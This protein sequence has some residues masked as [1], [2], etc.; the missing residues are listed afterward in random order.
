MSM[1]MMRAGPLRPRAVA[2][3]AGRFALPVL[4][5]GLLLGSGGPGPASGAGGESFEALKKA[6]ED[7]LAK[8]A[9][10]RIPAL[11]AIG[12]C[13]D[14]RAGKYIADLLAE[15]GKETGLLEVA[16]QCLGLRGDPAA[17][18]AA[19]T[20]G[21]KVL[22]ETRWRSVGE[23]FT[24]H[25]T[26][27]GQKWFLERGY[28]MIPTLPAAAQRIVV[29]LLL[30]ITDER[31]AEVA[32]KL[33]GNRKCPSA[34]QADFVDLLRIHRVAS[35]AKKI[36]GMHRFDDAKLQV[37]VLRALRD[38]E[39]AEHSK[40]FLDSIESKHWEVRSIAVDILGETHD[41]AMIPQITPL[42]SD[43][44][45]E[46]QVAAIQALRKIG[47]RDVVPPLIAALE[48]A[49]GR[50]RDDIADTLM[51]LLGADMGPDAIAWSTWWKLHGETAEVKGITR[52]EFDRL[53]E[54]AA[55]SQTGTYYGLRVIS[56]YVTF[57]I[58]VSGSM[59]EPYMVEER[60]VKK[61]EEE[62]K[63][64][65]SVAPSPEEKEKKKK[66]KKVERRKIEVAREELS[67]AITGLRDG[68]QFNM[69]PFDSRVQRYRD[70]LTV[71]SEEIRADALEFVAELK[72]G[73]MTNVYDSLMTAL[74]DPKVNTV[75]FLSD[76]APTNGKY[77]APEEIL[78]HV[79]AANELR[80]VKI[81]TIGFHLSPEAE[82]LMR[83]LAE[84]NYGTFVKR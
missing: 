18:E 66:K 19:L 43:P 16:V 54:A 13:P 8:P 76:G 22:P 41:P 71:M 25:L 26:A 12:E 60:D 57:V 73:G 67:R 46:V 21:F 34:I 48:K 10:D 44:F 74:E 52:E 68:V 28:A 80:K 62:E 40:I 78:V 11:R 2:R 63:G 20:H 17:L 79:R 47:G 49:P 77:V 1:G 3:G 32:E 64:G 14:P 69:I 30:G 27:D 58:D 51:W 61:G 4:L 59:E 23:S 56:E 6:Y 29:D 55:D 37:A 72:P 9:V 65:T 53:R 39:A 50:V 35:A 15:G 75:Y 84:E 33:L 7:Q 31:R 38:L 82:D 81:H 36:A 83:R 5:A 45:P 42:L 70:E 24:G